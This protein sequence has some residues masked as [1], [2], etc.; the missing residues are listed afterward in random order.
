ML[1]KKEGSSLMEVID[2]IVSLGWIGLLCL[3]NFSDYIV[4]Q[5]TYGS[6]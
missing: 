6:F 1:Y 3:L 2:P 5:G 4:C